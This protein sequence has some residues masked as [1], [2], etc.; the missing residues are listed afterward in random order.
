VNINLAAMAKRAHPNRSRPYVLPAIFTTQAQADTLFRMYMKIVRLWHDAARS[1]ILPAYSNT[2]AP[3]TRDAVSDIEA[4]I[5]RTE[6]ASV[7]AQLT[8]AQQFAA[9]ASDL[10][11]WH[12]RKLISSI[13][14][15]TDV[16]L[17]TFI[18]RGDMERTLAEALS[19]NVALVRNVSDEIRGKIAGSLFRGLQARTPVRDVAREIANATG[20][21]RD[22]SRRI[23]SDQTVKLAAQLD[24][25]RMEQLEI[26]RFEWRHSSKARPRPEHVARHGKI[27]EWTSEVARND[28]PGRLPFCGCK[29][30]AVIDI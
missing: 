13:K 1:E 16:D 29:A 7:V 9:W 15:A 23:A 2:V 19:A 28:P 24:Q 26:R 12:M 8:F 11:L 20:L 21:A 4:A 6:Q 30:R 18:G 22:R 25:E 27:Y 10:N 14:Y 5:S 3:G 17:E